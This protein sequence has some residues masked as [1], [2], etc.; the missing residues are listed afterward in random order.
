VGI[1]FG[2]DD[3]LLSTGG[4]RSEDGLELL[5]PRAYMAMM[6]RACGVMPYDTPY[7]NYKDTEGLKKET[8][9]IKKLG[10]YG[11]MLI[12]PS[13]IEPVKEILKPSP[14]E[15]ERARRIVEAYM[16]VM[17]R[18][19]GVAVVDGIAVDRPIFERAKK[20]IGGEYVDKG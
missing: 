15:V 12:H 11:K 2:A 8:V 16:D 19:S 5:F 18:G 10:F 9:L 7:V 3:Y 6:A 17:K 20:I 14:E 1:A 13:Q 4:E